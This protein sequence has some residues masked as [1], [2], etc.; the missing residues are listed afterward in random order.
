MHDVKNRTRVSGRC[1]RLTTKMAASK[2][3]IWIDVD[4]SP[5][6]PLFA[7]IIRHFRSN[8]VTVL[9]TA[10]DHS[11]TIELLDLHGFL[12]TYTVVGTHAGGNTLKKIAG[13]L[14]RSSQLARH[15]QKSGIKPTVAVSHGSR[16]MVLA[17]RWL[18]IPVIT[19]YDY[20]HTETWIFN[21]FSTRVL[22]PQMIPDEVLDGI[23]L[24]ADSRIKYPGLKEE[25]YLHYFSPGD[26]FREILT[27]FGVSFNDSAVVA[28]IRPP[29]TTANYH[30]PKSEKIFEAIL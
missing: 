3:A 21:R 12:G 28:V 22:V 7:P 26:A 1:E 30:D 19:M 11:Q 17:G 2:Q 25:V 14:S 24:N 10:R 23:G 5:H 16:S 15:I 8:D 9:L 29:A 6:V 13:L 18:K 4:N 27:E 20:E